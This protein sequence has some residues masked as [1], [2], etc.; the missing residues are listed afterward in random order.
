V[1]NIT[2]AHKWLLIAF[3]LKILFHKSQ[4]LKE[5]TSIF[6]PKF[7]EIW[8]NGIPRIDAPTKL[9]CLMQ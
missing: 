8:P 7:H 2:E 9:P 3:V 1:S 4:Y 5:M 6:L